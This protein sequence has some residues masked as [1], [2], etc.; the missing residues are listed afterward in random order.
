MPNGHSDPGDMVADDPPRKSLRVSTKIGTW[1]DEALPGLAM[2][3][4]IEWEMTPTMTPQGPA[5]A[6]VL[7]TPGMLLGTTVHSVAVLANP[8]AL[9]EDGVQQVLG[10]MLEALRQ[11]RGKATISNPAPNGQPQGPVGPGG[12]VMP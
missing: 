9:T 2:G 8:L 6:I 3:E 5:F 7:F 11:E 4:Q 12:I 1:I 10:G